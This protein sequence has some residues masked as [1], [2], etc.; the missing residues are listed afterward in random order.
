[1]INAN[2]MISW[3]F[4]DQ[5]GEITLDRVSNSAVI[6]SNGNITV[7]IPQIKMVRY[8]EQIMQ[9]ELNHGF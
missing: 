1:M 7:M 5:E 9:Q 2:T 4:H 8:M 3:K 6:L